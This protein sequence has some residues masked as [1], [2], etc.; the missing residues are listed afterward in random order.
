MTGV[1]ARMALVVL[2]LLLVL[3][4]LLLRGFTPD[5]ELQERRLRA[6]DAL[7]FNEAALHRDVL[8]ASHGLLLNYDPLVATLARLREVAAELRGAG[9]PGPLMDGI[10]AELDRQ[11]ALV[12]DFKS[13][14]ALLRNSVSYV[15]YLSEQLV[16]P[17]SEPG[18]AVAMV[19]GR[20]AS[21]MFRFV[22]SA[23]N[24]AEA[25]EVAAALDELSVQPVPDDLREDTAALRAHS[26]LILRN[27]PL[28]GGILARLLSTRVSEQARSLQEHFMEEQ[29]R[30]ESL[31]LI[32]RVLLYLAS[33]LLLIYLSHLYVRLR[34]NGRV[35]KARSG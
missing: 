18:Q 13:A 28:V 20:L 3:T 11:E 10:A 4:Y 9:A 8:K 12:E 25:A 19:V 34:A 17:T 23:S 22:G 27:Q 7:S 16:M 31:A 6:I 21:T 26:A 24:D 14:H 32:F 2:G 35:L 15:T 5:A 30:D 29:R 33:V 1:T